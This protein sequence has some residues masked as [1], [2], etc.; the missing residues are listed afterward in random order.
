MGIDIRFIVLDSN[1]FLDTVYYPQGMGFDMAID[2]QEPGPYGYW[3]WEFLRSPESGSSWNTSYYSNPELDEAYESYLTVKDPE[4]RKALVWKLQEIM[5][6]DLPI[7]TICRPDTIDAIRTDKLEGYVA[8]MGGI[9][10]WINS[11][12]YFNVHAKVE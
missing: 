7:Y 8:Y 12:T 1:T 11:Q 10:R 5:E 2:Y 6:T 9:S 3:I 4:A